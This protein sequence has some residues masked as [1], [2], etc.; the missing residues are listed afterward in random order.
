MQEDYLKK[1]VKAYSVEHNYDLDRFISDYIWLLNAI[2]REIW[3]NIRWKEKKVKGKKRILPVI[4][5]SKEFKRN[6]RNS[7]LKDWK[8]ASHYVDSAINTAY[9]ILKSWRKRYKKGQ[10]GRK[11]PVIKREFIYVK[12]TLFSYRNGVVK[13]T[14]V[15][16]KYYVEFDLKQYWFWDRVKN[17]NLGGIIL[18]KD[19]ITFTFWTMKELRIKNPVGWDANLMS[20]DGYD[21]QQHY[22]VSLKD[23][24]TIHRE[25]E[26]KRKRI[27]EKTQKTKPK[28]YK[29]LMAKYE[30]REQN[31]VDDFLHKISKSL[32]DRSHVFED[33]TYMKRNCKSKSRKRNRQLFK[34]DFIKLQKMI[35]YKANW[36]G[37]NV[38]YVPPKNT[39]KSCSRCGFV[40]ETRIG[41]VFTCPNCGLVMDRQMN[42]SINIFRKGLGVWGLGV[43]P[44]GDETDDMLPMNPEG[45]EVDVSQSVGVSIND[46]LR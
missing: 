16:R 24:Y 7:A 15:P 6:L 29:R 20:F 37:Y 18:K 10:A 22:K 32:S 46:H 14:I 8:Y 13:I 39:S 28:T 17:L 5:N 21:G 43:A 40:V 36:N 25:Y 31:R 33:L 1:V 12:T 42:A 34:G 19:S 35:E 2:M 9:S 26:L 41:A 38:A 11:M 44:N 3:N 45:V 4:P 27:Q 23:V 30:H